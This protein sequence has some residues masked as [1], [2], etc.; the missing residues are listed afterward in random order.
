MISQNTRG[1][2]SDEKIQELCTTIKSR[3]TFAAFLQETLRT[4]VSHLDM[5]TALSLVAN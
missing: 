1:Q 2:K 4:G 5:R 3:N